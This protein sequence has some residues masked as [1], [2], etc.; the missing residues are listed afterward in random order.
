MT[1]R[2]VLTPLMT[3]GIVFLL[4]I[5]ISPAG[6]PT[7]A[8]GRASSKRS[9]SPVG[10]LDKFW[11]F[12]QTAP[13]HGSPQALAPQSLNT[14]VPLRETA[15]ARH[16][17]ALLP[18]WRTE[19]FFG[20]MGQQARGSAV[21]AEVEAPTTSATTPQRRTYDWG[22]SGFPVTAET[23]VFVLRALAPSASVQQTPR[24]FLK[25]KT[26]LSPAR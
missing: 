26:T 24:E 23:R 6:S 12:R 1:P 8:R 11:C 25:F 7:S 13:P 14:T 17:L 16:H 9:S 21:L 19:R 5:Q 15:Q 22:T 4:P 20:G 3:R 10:R 2:C 18:V